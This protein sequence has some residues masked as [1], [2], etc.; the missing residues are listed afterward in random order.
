M[1][2]YLNLSKQ[3]LEERIFNIFTIKKY[4]MFEQIDRL[5]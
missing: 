3:K 5:P 4:K 2:L 1:M